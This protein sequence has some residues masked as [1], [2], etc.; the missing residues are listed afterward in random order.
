MSNFCPLKQI[1][2]T[3]NLGLCEVCAEVHR[4]GAVVH[5]DL[6]VVVADAV[7]DN[8][9]ELKGVAER[10]QLQE[11]L[12]AHALVD[13][14]HLLQQAHQRHLLDRRQIIGQLEKLF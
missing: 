6:H 3:T 11:A 2:E 12:E 14:R 10:G 13:L 9:L 8:P 1:A 7:H 5:P 4:P